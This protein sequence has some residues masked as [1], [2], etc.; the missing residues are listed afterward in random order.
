MPKYCFLF[1]ILLIHICPSVSAQ[2]QVSGRVYEEN[3]SLIVAA[4]VRNKNRKVSSYS[5]RDGR[6]HIFADEGDTLLF[7]AAGFIPD[8]VTVMLH[9]LLTSYDVT[10][11]R[12]SV[13]LERVEVSASYRQDS[14]DRHNFYANVLRKNPVVSRPA[15]GFGISFSPTGAFS[16]AARQKRALKKRLLQQDKEDYIDRS[17]PAEWVQR[18]TG[19][20]GDSLNLFMYRYRPS[21]DFCRN[22]DR[23][24]MTLY[25]NDK[26]KEFKK[27]KNDKRLEPGS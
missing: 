13:L 17:F 3:D 24:G 7:S 6:Y 5:D 9:M 25:I 20:K 2:V 1:V 15:N 4:T 8:T 26:L 23:P 27:P 14:I 22:T 12:K 10:L 19:L 16:K 21:Y 18:L 11:T